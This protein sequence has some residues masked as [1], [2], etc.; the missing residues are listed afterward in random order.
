MLRP[1][2]AQRPVATLTNAN[3]RR[4]SNLELRLF[5]PAT[6]PQRAAIEPRSIEIARNCERLRQFPGA[7][8][9]PD[10]RTMPIAPACHF[11]DSAQGL[12]GAD[13]NAARRSLA[14]GYHV[15]AFMH[16]VDEINVGPPGRSEYHL[17]TWS[18]AARSM[19]GEIVRPEIRLR[20]HQHACRFAVQ[21][22]TTEQIGC[23]FLRWPGKKIKLY[24][25]RGVQ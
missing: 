23:Q 17:S 19:G 21:Q 25:F 18:K 15:Q 22:D 6:D 14:V 1:N 7:V 2:E 8:R 9:Q 16:A 12:E 10:W 20:F 4:D 11:L 3:A 24:G 5:A 13:Q